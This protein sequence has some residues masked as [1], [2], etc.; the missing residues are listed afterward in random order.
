MSRELGAALRAALCAAPHVFSPNLCHLP[1]RQALF[2]FSCDM[3][4]K[5][6]LRQDKGLPRVTEPV[7]DRIRNVLCVRVWAAGGEGMGSV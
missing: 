4:R 6:R 7:G 2:F 3:M 5:L 1:G